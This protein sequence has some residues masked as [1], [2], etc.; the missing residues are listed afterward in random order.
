MQKV[1]AGKWLAANVC[2]WVSRQRR[3]FEMALRAFLVSSTDFRD[4]HFAIRNCI[5]VHGLTHCLQGIILM[6]MAAVKNFA[7][8]MISRFILGVFESVIFGGF[9]LIVAMWWKKEEQPWVSRPRLENI[10]GARG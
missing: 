6:S 9:G 2:V 4:A 5:L 8:L 3:A 10:L 7:G 1:P